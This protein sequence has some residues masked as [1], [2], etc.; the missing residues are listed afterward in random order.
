MLI[1][2]LILFFLFV[3]LRRILSSS[4]SENILTKKLIN[5][6]NNDKCSKEDSS[7][8]NNYEALDSEKYPNGKNCNSI[9]NKNEQNNS[10]KYQ[11]IDNKETIQ[12]TS[13]LNK[14]DLNMISIQNLIKNQTDL[15]YDYAKNKNNPN[16]IFGFG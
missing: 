16:S 15:D 6:L 10:H 11:A 5:Y 12:D 8:E 13:F 3:I 1:G 7:K 4:Q 14:E 9:N 2:L